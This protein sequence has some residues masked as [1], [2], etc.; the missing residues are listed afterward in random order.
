[1]GI[2]PES[3][4]YGWGIIGIEIGSEIVFLKESV[5][6]TDSTDFRRLFSRVFRRRYRRSLKKI[7]IF[8]E[9][10]LL[11]APLGSHSYIRERH[12]LFVCFLRDTLSLIFES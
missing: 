7:D 5:I 8:G 4:D 10:M 3:Q 9:N 11:V 2:F 1:M 6:M 12:I